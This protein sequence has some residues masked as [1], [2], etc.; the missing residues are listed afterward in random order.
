[1]RVR[2]FTQDDAHIFAAMTRSNPSTAFIDLLHKVYADFG[3][4]RSSTSSRPD[5]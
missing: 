1:M 2:G 5:R 4:K 3:F